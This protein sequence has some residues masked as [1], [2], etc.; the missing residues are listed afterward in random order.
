[1]DGPNIERTLE[2]TTL[3]WLSKAL[4]ELE[5]KH[6]RKIMHPDLMLIL[7]LDPEIAVQRKTDEE[8]DHVRTR[9]QEIWET[10]WSRTR[11]RLVDA[12]QSPGG[13]LAEL[14]AQIWQQI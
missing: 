14:R 13:V 1:M 3:T 11:A 4:L 7:R 5:N 6:Y 12:R 10:D 9:S 2:G 8:E